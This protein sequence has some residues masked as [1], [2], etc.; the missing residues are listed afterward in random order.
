MRTASIAILCGIPAAR[1]A[2]VIGRLIAVLSLLLLTSA[3]SLVDSPLPVRGYAVNVGSSTL[4]EDVLLLNIV[5]ASRFE[6]MNFVSLS[7]YNASG[8]LEAGGQA[9]HNEGLLYDILNKG[10]IAAGTTATGTIVKN[11]LVPNAKANTAANFDLAPL[12]NKEFYAGLLGQ[13]G[14]ETI[15]LMVNAGLSRELVLHSLV[16]AAR[17]HYANGDVVQYHNDPTNDS[18]LGDNSPAS[19]RQCEQIQRERAFDPPFSHPIWSPPHATDCNY[20]KFLFFLRSAVMYGLT[21]EVVEVRSD[22]KGGP[23][24][25]VVICYDPAI[26][27][28]YGKIITPEVRCG[29]RIPRQ[30]FQHYRDFGPRIRLI[31]PVL[32]SPYAVFQ[33]FGRILATETAQKVKL[34]D[35]RTPRLPTNDSAILT[36]LK[37]SSVSGCFAR[38]YH[39]GETYCVPKAGAN[40]TKEIFVLLNALIN[41][42]TT[43]SALPTTPTVQLAP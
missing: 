20:Q 17:V 23:Q 18:W 35:A 28:E 4:R 21:T 26:A 41:L 19:Q 12:E 13:I 24:S 16:K 31:Q 1:W 15:N 39:D 40:N 10:P 37:G 5:R 22:R 3:C 11:A 6:P 36:V 2:D 14:L 8:I 33:Y 34:I 30:G 29:A 9:T 32:R 38:A 7:K 25:A 42:S 27:Q 43:R